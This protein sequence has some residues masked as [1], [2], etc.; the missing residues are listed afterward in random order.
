MTPWLRCFGA[1]DERTKQAP[2]IK[3]VWNFG[4]T[5]TASCRIIR[6]SSGRL[7]A[8]RS[9]PKKSTAETQFSAPATQV[10]M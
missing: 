2:W 7:R 8:S 10:E 6:S 3:I 5:G 1:W 4:G 9:L